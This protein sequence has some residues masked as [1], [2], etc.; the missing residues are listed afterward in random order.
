MRNQNVAYALADCALKLSGLGARPRMLHIPPAEDGGKQGGDDFIQK[1]GH[2]ALQ[3]LPKTPFAQVEQLH[4]INS[5]WAFIRTPVCIYH[6]PTQQA[7]SSSDF[8]LIENK[9]SAIVPSPKGDKIVKAGTQWLIWPGRREYAALTYQPG[10][11]LVTKRGELNTFPDW[12]CESI[13]D[14]G[15]DEVLLFLWLLD[16]L[17]PNRKMR[18]WV[19]QWARP[20]DPAPLHES[21]VGARLLRPSRNRTIIVD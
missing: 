9:N 19:L 14:E 15:P 12:G 1:H 7:V 5:E 16:R 3:Q 11:P 10:E 20:H 17:V 2:I 21:H 8:L 18:R 6:I 4:R 13:R